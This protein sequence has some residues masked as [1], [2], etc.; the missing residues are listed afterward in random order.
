[1]TASEAV[2]AASID[3][4]DPAWPY[5]GK[6]VSLLSNAPRRAMLAEKTLLAQMGIAPHLYAVLL[7]SGE[8]VH[9]A[10]RNRLDPWHA[11]LYNPC[12]HLGPV[13]DRGVFDGLGLQLIDRPETAGFCVATGIDLNDETLADYRQVLDRGLELGLPMICANPDIIVP[14]GETF[15]VCAGAFADYYRVRGGDVFWHGKPHKPIYA[16][17]FAAL[18]ALGGPVDPA[19]TI[20]IGD[21]LPTDILGARKAG[22]ASALV[23]GGIHRAAVKLNWRGRPDETAL[24]ELLVARRRDRNLQSP[25]GLRRPCNL[26]ASDVYR[27]LTYSATYGI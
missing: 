12:W 8:A 3:A 1:M 19:R 5:A 10:L 24:A 22:V 11:R 25:T 21:G 15:V 16:R 18:E 14:V 20:A 6:R 17:L 26:Y 2:I 13:R 9:A 23:L 27:T 7:T 4:L